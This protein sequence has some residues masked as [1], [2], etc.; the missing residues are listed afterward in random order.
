MRAGAGVVAGLPE[1]VCQGVDAAQSRVG[2]TSVD[3]WSWLPVQFRTIQEARDVTAPFIWVQAD[4]LLRGTSAPHILYLTPWL[5]QLHLGNQPHGQSDIPQMTDDN[6]DLVWYA[7]WR[8]A[9]GQDP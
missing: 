2:L 3:G 1:S 8:L 9:S 6:S 5:I 4:S 7:Y